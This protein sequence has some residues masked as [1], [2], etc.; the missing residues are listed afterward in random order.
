M[1]MDELASHGD[2][3]Y[4]L[5]HARTRRHVRPQ[6]NTF[7]HE[8]IRTRRRVLLRTSGRR[9]FGKRAEMAESLKNQR[10]GYDAL[11]LRR[12]SDLE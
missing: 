4:V 6:N 11:L 7:V 3:K 1:W 2:F 10:G 12:C 5:L 9:E 8:R